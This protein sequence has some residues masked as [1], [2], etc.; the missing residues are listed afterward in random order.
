MHNRS[1]QFQ[2]SRAAAAI[3]LSEIGDQRAIPLL[4]ESLQSGIFDLQ[5]ASLLGLKK[6]SETIQ[7]DWLP[8]NADPLIR[9]KAEAIA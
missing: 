1:P 5:Y 2:K 9:A 7:L 8:E 3:A 6:L 4:K